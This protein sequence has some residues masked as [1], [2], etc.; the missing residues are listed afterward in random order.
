MSQAQASHFLTK[1]QNDQK[2]FNILKSMPDPEAQYAL[3]NQLG[4]K[5]TREELH[6]AMQSALQAVNKG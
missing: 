3:A 4:F 5:F 6:L 1:V 2:L